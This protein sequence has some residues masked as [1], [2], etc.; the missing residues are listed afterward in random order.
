MQRNSFLK[1]GHIP[2][3]I[4]AFMY[5]DTRLASWFGYYFVR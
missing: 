5:F 1:S 2:T 4:S 3:L